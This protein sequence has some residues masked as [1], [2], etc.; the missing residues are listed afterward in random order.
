MQRVRDDFA[1]LADRVVAMNGGAQVRQRERRDSENDQ[2]TSGEH[3]KRGVPPEEASE[4]QSSR[5]AEHGRD[6]ECP[7]DH[8]HRLAA[9]RR[10]DDVAD[11][12][13]HH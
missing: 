4:I 9:P 8:A 7:H 1:H 6:R 2:R 5:D 12:R 10:R 13:A 11:H 3:E